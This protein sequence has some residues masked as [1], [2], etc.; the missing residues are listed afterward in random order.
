MIGL[1]VALSC[2]QISARDL[3][4]FPPLDQQLDALS[5][6]VAESQGIDG[7]Q[8]DES[9]RLKLQA[10]LSKRCV[11]WI[12]LYKAQSARKIVNLEVLRHHLGPLNYLNGRMPPPVWWERLLPP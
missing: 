1:L 10:C 8:R 3:S 9:E 7:P 2:F 4:R 6:F 11:P 12:A 5:W